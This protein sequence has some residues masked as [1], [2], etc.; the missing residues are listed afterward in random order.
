MLLGVC[1]RSRDVAG[2]TCTNP[3]ARF[4][5]GLICYCLR[6]R[7]TLYAL[8]DKLC[9]E[10][11][12]E[13]CQERS[14]VPRIVPRTVYCTKNCAKKCVHTVPTTVPTTTMLTVLRM[15]PRCWHSSTKRVT[16]V[17]FFKSGETTKNGCI[18]F[19][20]YGP[21]LVKLKIKY[22]RRNLGFTV[23]NTVENVS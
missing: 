12:Q 8:H 23:E 2:V 10:L 14:T 19:F 21:G 20:S 13:L 18:R 7:K 6:N 22:S 11:Y 3:R 5:C 17:Q 16:L 9:Q 1:H 4:E 15:V